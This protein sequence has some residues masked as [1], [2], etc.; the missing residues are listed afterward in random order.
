[1]EVVK[2]KSE[3]VE[4]TS[5]MRSADPFDNA[6]SSAAIPNIP[7]SDSPFVPV[8]STEHLRSLCQASREEVLVSTSVENFN[9]KVL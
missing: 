6:R 4:V 1:M 8:I 5:T 9:R 3:R 7:V 2:V